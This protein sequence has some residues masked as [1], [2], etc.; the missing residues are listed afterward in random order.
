[1]KSLI[2]IAFVAGALAFAALAA[3]GSAAAASQA[4]AQSTVTDFSAHRY[5]RRHHRQTNRAYH[6]P[7]YYDR[8]VYYRPYPYAS[9]APFIFGIGYGPLW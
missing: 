1:M 5:A 8:P 9:P 7:T 6:Q 2:G 4:E 3:T